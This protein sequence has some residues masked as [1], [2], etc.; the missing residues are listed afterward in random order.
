MLLGN[1]HER[2]RLGVFDNLI[3]PGILAQETIPKRNCMGACGRS[4]LQA[5]GESVHPYLHNTAIFK[6][7]QGF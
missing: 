3:Q 7:T 1:F 5:F 4:L 6:A 2:M